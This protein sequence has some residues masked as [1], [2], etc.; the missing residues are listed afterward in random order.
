MTFAG[1]LKE[2]GR[3]IVAHSSSKEHI[4]T[5]HEEGGEEIC[6][7]FLPEI[8]IMREM[9]R[10]AG[11]ETVTEQDDEEYYIAIAVKK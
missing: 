4:N 11:L 1:C 8:D 3:L 5:I 6:T 10:R 2:G 9:M 7:D